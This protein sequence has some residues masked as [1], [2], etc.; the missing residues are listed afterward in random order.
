[1]IHWRS[2]KQS[3]LAPHSFGYTNA[4]RITSEP[5]VNESGW[6][7]TVAILL[8]VTSCGAPSRTPL[9]PIAFKIEAPAGC[10][11]AVRVYSYGMHLSDATLERL[12]KVEMGRQL[13]SAPSLSCPDQAPISV[14]WRVSARAG[15]PSRTFVGVELSCSDSKPSSAYSLTAGADDPLIT[16]A[17]INAVRILTRRIW[18]GFHRH[19][20]AVSDA[21][22][23]SDYPPTIQ[24]SY[25]ERS[26][27]I[28]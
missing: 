23:L 8:F 5:S 16:S 7:V 25:S 13:G 10:T 12:V 20:G 11:V 18:D 6:A 1:V 21:R 27:D 4:W 24:R 14:V 28:P 2:A 17:L 3:E 26:Q 15:R 22:S 9:P 19:S